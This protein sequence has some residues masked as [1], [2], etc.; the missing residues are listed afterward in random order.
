M[1]K[2]GNELNLHQKSK[3]KPRK[4]QN[5]YCDLY[6]S[7]NYGSFSFPP[8]SHIHQFYVVTRGFTRLS[9]QTKYV[10][11]SLISPHTNFS[12]NPMRTKFYY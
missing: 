5:K 10:C 6:K 2:K 8:T 9:M 11:H 7:L 12:N 1:F 4:A 3:V